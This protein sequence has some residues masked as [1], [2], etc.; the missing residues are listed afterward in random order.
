MGTESA[1]QVAHGKSTHQAAPGH[2]LVSIMFLGELLGGEIVPAVASHKCAEHYRWEEYALTAFGA[3]DK[4][5]AVRAFTEDLYLVFTVGAK[6]SH[7]YVCCILALKLLLLLLYL[8]TV[9]RVLDHRY[10]SGHGFPFSCDISLVG[11]DI[12]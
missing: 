10:S 2:D 7:G 11:V 6:P 5:C 4:R 3:F 9:L 1:N 8:S 12:D